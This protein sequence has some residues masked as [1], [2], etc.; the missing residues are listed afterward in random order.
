MIHELKEEKA[1]LLDQ[2]EKV[3][4]GFVDELDKMNAEMANAGKDAEKSKLSKEQVAHHGCTARAYAC[5]RM[6][7]HTH[8]RAHRGSNEGTRQ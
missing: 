6:H 1:T 7:A 8:A 3:R 4:M 2:I 5:A